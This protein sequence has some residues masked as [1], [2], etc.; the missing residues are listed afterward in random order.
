MS[1]DHIIRALDGIDLSE[2]FQRRFRV[3]QGGPTPPAREISSSSQERF[4][5]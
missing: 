3:M 5:S 2:V 4:G 1:P